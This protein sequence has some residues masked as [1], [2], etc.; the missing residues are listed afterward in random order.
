ML[1]SGQ[2]LGGDMSCLDHL[3]RLGSIMQRV[4]R[5]ENAQVGPGGKAGIA[6]LVSDLGVLL[7]GEIDGELPS[8]VEGDEGD[9]PYNEWL[10]LRR[11]LWYTECGHLELAP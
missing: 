3:D 11:G 4:D 6:V 9:A 1:G 5:A 2:R 8:G 7:I 10:I